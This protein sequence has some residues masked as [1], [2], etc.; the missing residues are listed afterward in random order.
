M[1]RVDQE[2][3]KQVLLDLST[4]F[5]INCPDQDYE[6]FDRLFFQIEKAHWYYVDF[7]VGKEKS[8]PA[9]DLPS[10]SVHLFKTCPLLSTL[11]TDRHILQCSKQ[12][13][14]YKALI[15]VG[16][17]IVVN[18]SRTKVALIKATQT[19]CWAFPRGKVNEV[20]LFKL[21]VGDSLRLLTPLRYSF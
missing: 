14:H 19:N 20:N 13:K 7:V 21:L 6:S 1:T 12:F 10:F 3:F 9:L 4:R 8:L 17:G 16:G 15:P 2:K 5:I 11:F 18:A